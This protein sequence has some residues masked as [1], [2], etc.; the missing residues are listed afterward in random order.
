MAKKR[1]RRTSRRNWQSS[2]RPVGGVSGTGEIRAS[3]KTFTISTRRK[4]RPLTVKLALSLSAGIFFCLTV[5]LFVVLPLFAGSGTGPRSA[6]AYPLDAK[7][8]DS[9]RF[10]VMARSY[11]RTEEG[12]LIQVEKGG[13][14]GLALTT[15]SHQSGI[16]WSQYPYLKIRFKPSEHSRNMTV[17]WPASGER[18]FSMSREVPAGNS[19]TLFNT[20]SYKPGSDANPVSWG[21]FF[22]ASPV[23]TVVAVFSEDFEIR[24]AELLR[25]VSYGEKLALVAE[26]L[27]DEE[28]LLYRTING[29]AGHQV[30]G[31][32]LVPLFG[33][34]LVLWLLA[35]CLLGR[36]DLSAIALGAGMII[37]AYDTL[38]LKDYLGYMTK[39]LPRSAW[40]YDLD[41]ERRSYYGED[42]ADLAQEFEK[43]VAPGA[44]VAFLPPQ[45]IDGRGN[46]WLWLHLGYLYET[47]IGNRG[48]MDW[49]K[50]K[51][52]D[53]VFFYYPADFVLDDRGRLA[54]RTS[55]KP[56]WEDRDYRLDLLYEASPQ[57]RLYR[58]VET[59]LQTVQ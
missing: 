35:S 37:V 38:T 43:R 39:S 57:A 49:R 30:Y 19:E 14:S 12:I 27:S 53:Y 26:D 41:E 33:S 6:V 1:N 31:F 24:G 5:V 28:S 11:Q 55:G 10:K 13:L 17:R 15:P 25:D 56:L 23:G 20:Y 36:L 22:A 58:L 40:H 18:K 16:R 7:A 45:Y 44:K 51:Q 48:S 52:A 54:Q 4:L 29:V 46:N 21:G 2:R 3:Q 59:K 8:E 47:H 9:G 34:F 42:F 50:I 32:L